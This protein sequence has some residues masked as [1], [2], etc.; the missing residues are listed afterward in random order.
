MPRVPARP[1]AVVTTLFGVREAMP[2]ICATIATKTQ[3]KHSY[4]AHT[5]LDKSISHHTYSIH[6]FLSQKRPCGCAIIAM[7]YM[8][9]I[10][11]TDFL[12]KPTCVPISIF[13][14]VLALQHRSAQE[15]RAVI[16]SQTLFS[17][18]IG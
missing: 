13:A 6:N 14:I 12:G 9:K 3:T 2:L 11:G 4:E 7:P 5:N 8:L 10:N 17:K 16:L 1:L 15:V 18:N